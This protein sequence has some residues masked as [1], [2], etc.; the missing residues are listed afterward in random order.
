MYKFQRYCNIFHLPEYLY[1][2]SKGFNSPFFPP[3]ISIGGAFL[4]DAFSIH[5]AQ[6]DANL[7]LTSGVPETTYRDRLHQKR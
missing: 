3:K 2:H 6:R 7:Q 5:A 1:G 4:A